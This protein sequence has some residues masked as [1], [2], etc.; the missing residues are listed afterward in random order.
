MHAN[1]CF[2]SELFPESEGRGCP[3]RFVE[4]IPEIST[5]QRNAENVI[6]EHADAGSDSSRALFLFV[7]LIRIMIRSVL[8]ESG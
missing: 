4:S 8:S 5:G 6:E 3:L 7:V 2:R 1:H